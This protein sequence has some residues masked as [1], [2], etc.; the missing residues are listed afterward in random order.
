MASQTFRP[1]QGAIFPLTPTTAYSGFRTLVH[2]R[3]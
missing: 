1:V 2:R 3:R